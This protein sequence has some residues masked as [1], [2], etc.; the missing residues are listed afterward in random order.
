MQRR[1]YSY[2]EKYILPYVKQFGFR[3]KHFTINAMAELREI[4]RMA[5]EKTHNISV[6]LDLKN[7]FDTLDHSVLLDK[8]EAHGVGG[9]AN[10]RFERY[11]LNR[12]KFVVSNCQ[13]SPL[14]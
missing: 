5:S 13:A 6:F 4:I 14:G 9:V 11:L 12:L 2:L 7:A 3:K 10:K 1:L 8:L